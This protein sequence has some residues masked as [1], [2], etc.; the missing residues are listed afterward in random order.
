MFLMLVVFLLLVIQFLL[1]T[2]DLFSVPIIR[3]NSVFFLFSSSYNRTFQ[4]Q[5][6]NVK[7]KV[8]YDTEI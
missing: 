5:C 6:K 1:E 4:P 3:L 8:A 7:T 2:K